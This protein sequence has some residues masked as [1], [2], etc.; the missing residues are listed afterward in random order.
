[1]ICSFF[2]YISYIYIYLYIRITYLVVYW[3]IYLHVYLSLFIYIYIY[4]WVELLQLAGQFK[5]GWFTLSTHLR[6]R[7]SEW[8]NQSVLCEAILFQ[9]IDSRW[10]DAGWNSLWY[11]EVNSPAAGSRSPP[12]AAVPAVQCWRQQLPQPGVVNVWCW[13]RLGKA[14]GFKFFSCWFEAFIYCSSSL[15]WLKNWEICVQLTQNHHQPAQ[16]TKLET[17]GTTKPT[18]H[19]FL[20]NWSSYWIQKCHEIWGHLLKNQETSWSWS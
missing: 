17:H 9:G 1:M 11:T 20:Q 14:S 10:R 6:L 18:W 12:W 15:E 16:A 13:A 2:K 7:Q 19:H 5:S 3:F 8:L 4:P